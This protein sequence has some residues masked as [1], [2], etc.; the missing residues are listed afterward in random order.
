MVVGLV[1]AALI[2]VSAAQKTATGAGEKTN[3]LVGRVLADVSSFAFGAGLGPKYTTFIFAVEADGGKRVTPVKVSYAFFKSE[4]P[5]PDSF[6]DHSKR[7]E[8]QALRDTK[9]DESVNSLSY[10]KNVDQSGNSLQPTY[11]VR[12]LEGAP[13]D[14]L[15]S[16][17]IL[18]CYT[19]RPGKY[20]VLS[21][22]TERKS[23]SAS[24]NGGAAT[25]MTH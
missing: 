8:L 21:Q 19:L 20:K 13:K 11:V 17:A 6:F 15:K 9:C 4:G 12:F 25:P 18:P 16:D 5:P 3:R 14:V 22:G 23:G 24:P 7:Y 2:S 1:V 10:V